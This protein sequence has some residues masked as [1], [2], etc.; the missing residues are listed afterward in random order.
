MLISVVILNWNGEKFLRDYLPS[1]VKYSSSIEDCE[2]VVADNGSDDGSLELL[3]RDFSSVRI[4]KLDQNY[5]FTGG[6][7]RAIKECDSKYIMLLN[8]DVVVSEGYLEPLLAQLEGDGS[9]GAVM[10][11]ILSL[12]EPTK[13]E[14]AG[15][16]GGFLDV[17]GLPYCRGRVMSSTEVD[18]GQYD[19]TID[20]F[21]ASGAAMVI[22]RELYEEL[23]GLDDDFFAHMEEI[24][25][26]WRAKNR[27]Y[28]IKC[29]SKSKVYHLGGGTLNN[30]SPRKLYFN[31]RN[32]LFMLYKNLRWQRLYITLFC[33]MC[34][35][36][37][38]ALLY[39]FTGGFAKFVAVLKAHRDFYRS[40]GS[41]KAKRGEIVRSN[42]SFTRGFLPFILIEKEFKKIKK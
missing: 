36:G 14:Y 4:I 5:G 16:A 26:C 9:V 20:I 38:V 22:R 13:F 41:L 35:D 10:P 1:V 29:V 12:L 11:K 23:G 37:L 15:A 18:R 7:N 28:K 34:F 2:V 8:S 31:F 17:I 21:W 25:L 27:G 33:R 19:N 3:K 6:Y 30:N 24:D 32:S 42:R 39:L 40:L